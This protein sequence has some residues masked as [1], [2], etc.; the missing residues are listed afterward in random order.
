M[1]LAALLAEQ[2]DADLQRLAIEH[3]RTDEKLARPQL[4][5]FL[6]GALRSFSFVSSFIVNR[7]P[8][9]CSILTSLL[10]S[11]GYERPVIGFKEAVMNDTGRLVDLIEQD[12]LLA[13]ERQ[14]HPSLFDA[15]ASREPVPTPDRVR[16]MLR[17]KTR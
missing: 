2:S 8:P 16:D 9:T 11:P 12:E 15:F 10:E 13:R 5:N 4:C 1:R 6:E 7:Q 14:L 3:V 17:S